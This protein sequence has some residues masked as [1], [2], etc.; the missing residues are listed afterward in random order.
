[1]IA[2][3]AHQRVIR[4]FPDPIGRASRRDGSPK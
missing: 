1:M 3:P 4:G 2:R